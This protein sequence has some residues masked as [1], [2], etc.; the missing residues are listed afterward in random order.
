MK[1]KEHLNLFN[2]LVVYNQHLIIQIQ[3]QN[4]N[5]N[6][7]KKKNNKVINKMNFKKLEIKQDK[8]DN[9]KLLIKKHKY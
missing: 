8:K 5:F 2:Q 6:N 3:N 7:N 9:K 4:L 1:I